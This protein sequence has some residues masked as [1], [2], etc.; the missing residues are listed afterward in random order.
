MTP[1]RHA[2][3]VVG[4]WA[5]GEHWE[6]KYQSTRSHS[7][8]TCSTVGYSASLSGAVGKHALKKKEDRLQWMR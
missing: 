1:F 7:R 3:A 8:S 4:R 6:G 2:V 5:L